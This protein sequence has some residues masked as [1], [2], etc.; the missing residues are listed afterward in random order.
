MRILLSLAI[1]VGSSTGLP[2]LPQRPSPLAGPAS[3]PADPDDLWHYLN[4]APAGQAASDAEIEAFIADYQA[5]RAQALQALPDAERL[6][7]CLE[8]LK[9]K[10]HC[11]G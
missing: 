2:D 1:F 4:E 7:E 6:I 3:P 11:K 8:R 9:R 5:R 10:L